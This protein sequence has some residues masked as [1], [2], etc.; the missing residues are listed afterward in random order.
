MA[1]DHTRIR[2]LPVWTSDPALT[3][4]KGGVSNVSYLATD[5]SGRYV[6]RM[7]ESY[8]FH[9]VDRNREIIA[10][11]AAYATG[12]S[13][14]LIHVASGAMVFRYIDA[15]TYGEQQVRENWQSCMQMIAR[16][17]HDMGRHITGQGAIFWVFQ[18]IRDYCATLV[19]QKHRSADDVPHWLSIIDRL[20]KEQVPL[21][22]IFGH[23]DLLCGNF[24]DDGKRLWL[25]DWEYAAF[26]TALFDLANLAANNSFDPQRE[27]LLL[28]A[29]FDHKADEA[30]LRAFSAMK[31]ASALREAIWGMISE[32][33][34]KAPGVDYIAYAAEN[35]GRFDA[36]YQTHQEKFGKL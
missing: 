24:L 11:R 34:L 12:L 36:A 6:V 30:L 33:Y 9:Q 20:E 23:H 4:L 32:I 28:E 8:P 22:V 31:T 16:C 13:P 3:P 14:E 5:S 1:D 19:V 25:I 21:P 18:I 17:H 10:S 26:G 7:G 27:T 35:L 2:Q 15:T 29:Y